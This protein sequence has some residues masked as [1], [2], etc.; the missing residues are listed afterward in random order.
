MTNVRDGQPFFAPGRGRAEE[1][2]FGVG[3][4]RAVLKIFGAGAA[5]FPGAGAGRAS[6]VF[7]HL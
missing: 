6:L 2:K 5:I 7:V 3:R 1:N 4:G